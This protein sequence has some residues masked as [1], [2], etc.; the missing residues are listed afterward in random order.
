MSLLQPPVWKAT[1]GNPAVPD[2]GRGCAD[3]EQAM[4]ANLR[5]LG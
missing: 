4:L 1:H 3:A 5:L 2:C